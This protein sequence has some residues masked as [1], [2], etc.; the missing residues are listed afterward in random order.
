MTVVFQA[1]RTHTLY[2]IK[3]CSYCIEEKLN[4]IFFG[5]IQPA[6]IC[7]KDLTA[8]AQIYKISL[9]FSD[10]PVAGI[11]SK[12]ESLGQMRVLKKRQSK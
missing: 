12:C 4:V 5:K 11:G 9:V 2:L 1:Y 6:F 10:V 3:P 8:I 7:D